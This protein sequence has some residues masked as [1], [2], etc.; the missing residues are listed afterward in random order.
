M[1][2]DYRI[3]SDLIHKIL[4][5]PERHAHV[6]SDLHAGRAI[7]LISDLARIHEG[8]QDRRTVTRHRTAPALGATGQTRRVA[9]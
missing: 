5:A 4:D 9:V 7:A 6:R 2:S 8:A 3:T 1:T